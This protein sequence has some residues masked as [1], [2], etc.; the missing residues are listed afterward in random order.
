[1]D[2]TVKEK[3]SVPEQFKDAWG[4]A[5]SAV[6]SAE[7]EAQRALARISE[8]AGWGP[9]EARRHVREFSERLTAQRRELERSLEAGV[10]RALGRV[11][12]PRRD[13]VVGLQQ[14]VARLAARVDA[15]SAKR[16]AAR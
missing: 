7:D 13:D 16:K 14:R 10:N 3:R 11:K 8:L 2:A 1:M 5:L 12:L 15:L 4:Q 9:D 6:T